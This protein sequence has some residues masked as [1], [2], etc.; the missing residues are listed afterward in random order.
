[1]KQ[2]RKKQTNKL[3]Y[4]LLMITLFSCQE[5]NIKYDGNGKKKYSIENGDNGF[6]VYYDSLGNVKKKCKIEN[7]VPC[8][9]CEEYFS[10]G[11]VSEKY[12]VKNN[13]I[14]GVYFSYDTNGF[15]TEKRKY[16]DNTVNGYVI[17]YNNEVMNDIS[18]FYKNK[19]YMYYEKGEKNDYFE[20][21]MKD[22]VNYDS[23]Y[24]IKFDFT[25]YPGTKNIEFL[26]GKIYEKPTGALYCKDYKLYKP[27]GNSL[28]IKNLA[29]F[30]GV[31]VFEGI[32]FIEK[33]FAD[34]TNIMTYPIFEQFYVK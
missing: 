11:K 1:M 6:V 20:M 15:L 22:T 16:Y 27:V 23:E 10:N 25:N 31:N 19:S 33:K 12:F 26:K 8:G 9:L 30:R 18:L 28:I 3:Y 32:I 5:D 14:E 24:S 4:I 17:G 7:R 2:L 29:Y 34:T 21:D 13:K